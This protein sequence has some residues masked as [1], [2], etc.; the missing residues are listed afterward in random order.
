MEWINQ[1][2][3]LIAFYFIALLKKQKE[4][5]DKLKS[6]TFRLYNLQDLSNIQGSHMTTV[7]IPQLIL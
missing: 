1:E 2:L 5:W 3:Q 4:V 7:P 6:L